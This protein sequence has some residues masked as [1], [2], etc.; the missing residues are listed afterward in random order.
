[1]AQ[2]W[3]NLRMNLEINKKMPL[4]HW[5][6]IQIVPSNTSE[7]ALLEETQADQ[8]LRGRLEK[9]KSQFVYHHGAV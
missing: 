8:Y 2:K 9:V 3:P 7:Q 5:A 1:M 4:Q 6:K